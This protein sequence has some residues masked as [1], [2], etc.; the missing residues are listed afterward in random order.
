MKKK[1]F[2]GFELACIEKFK[3]P[4]EKFN[5]REDLNKWAQEELNKKFDLKQYH[6]GN[7]EETKE[8]LERLQAW[9]EYLSR[10]NNV[11]DKQPAKSLVIFDSITKEVKK[12]NR[13]QPPIL[14]PGV[15]ARTVEQVEKDGSYNQ[16]FAKL[17]I[18][19]LCLYE[20]GSDEDIDTGET[21]TGWV[22]IPSKEHDPENFENNVQRLKTLSHRS[23]CTKTTHAEPYLRDGDFHVYLENGKPKA[24]IRLFGDNIEEIQGEKNN[25][26]IPFKYIETIEDYV[27]ENNLDSGK[28]KK[29]IK[30]AK[31]LREKVEKAK[32]KISVLIDKKDYDGI[33]K[34]FGIEVTYDEDGKRV[35]SEYEQL[36]INFS[37]EDLGINENALLKDVVRIVENAD[38][39]NSG[40][41]DLSSLRSIGKNAN[42][43]NSKVTNLSSLE[44]IGRNAEFRNSK[45]TDL[46]SLQS[47]GK[48]A[49]FNNSQVTDLSSLKSIGGYADFRNSKVSSLPS[50]T[51]IGGTCDIKNSCLKPEDFAKVKVKGAIFTA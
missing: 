20:M 41:T 9:I 44:S 4:V 33:L 24:G 14:N 29:E 22:K 10:K 15:L 2:K 38:F 28:V 37:C 31:E 11:Y 45:V 34:K 39:E 49:H 36:D 46:S 40:V 3:A 27:K 30:E 25:G 6:N 17:Y 50:L 7:D 12:D 47:V 42:F 8:R 1:Q 23:W 19:N 48:N 32:A 18:N 16:N 26:K 43:N 5:T 13:E 21:G 35:L 51:K